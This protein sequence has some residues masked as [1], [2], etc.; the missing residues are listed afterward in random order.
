M[1]KKT[2]PASGGEKTK[3]VSDGRE[4]TVT[5]PPVVKP[6]EVEVP[7]TIVLVQHEHAEVAV[8][9]DHSCKISSLPPPLEYS[10][11]CI[12]FGI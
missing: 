9:E 2:P 1:Q 7:L 12:L 8:R 6:V 10:L 5:I 11:D 4:D 3:R